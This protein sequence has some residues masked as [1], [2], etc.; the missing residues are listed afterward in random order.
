[1]TRL[2][3]GIGTL[4]RRHPLNL[5]RYAACL[6]F[7]A[8]TSQV[9]RA[10]E[11]QWWTD[12]KKACGLSPSL[13]YETWRQQ[14]FPCNQQATDS[15]SSSST[16]NMA[17]GH[18]LQ[19]NIVS[20]GAN[21]MVANIQDSTTRSFM[22]GFT[23]SFLQRMFDNEQEAARQRQ[24][25]EQ[26]LAEQRRRMEEQRRIAEQQRLD[27][28]F[29]RLNSQLKLQGLPF[30]LA[31][32]PM[33]SGE[34]LQLK[35]MNSSGPD[36]LKLKLGQS[37]STPTSYGLKGLPGIYVG[38]PA[39]TDTAGAQS[40]TT[41]GNPNLA[42]GPGTGTT[43][44]GI[45]GLP[46]IY[47]DRVQPQEAPELAQAATHLSGPD[48]TLAQDVALQ[49]AK[50]NPVLSGPSD[51]PTIQDFQQKAQQYDGAQASAKVAQDQWNEAQSRVDSDK[52]ALDMARAKVESDKATPDQQQAFKQMV[53]LAK[54]DEDAAQRAREIFDGASAHVSLTRADAASALASLVPATGTSTNTSSAHA[55]LQTV[56]A[57]SSVVDLSQAHTSTP[58]TLKLGTSNGVPIPTGPPRATAVATTTP[59]IQAV[60][61][62][63]NGCLVT[64]A[65]H[66]ISTA[67]LPSMEQLRAQLEDAEERI[68]RMVEDREKQ[69]ELGAEAAQQIKDAQ[70][71][72]KKQAIELTAD[73]VLHKAIAGVRSG[74]WESG[75]E[76]SNL[77]K[78]A[79]A[80]TDPSKLAALQS[81]IQQ[82]TLRQQNLKLAKDVL[83]NGKDRLEEYERLRDFHEWASKPADLQKAT[84]QMEG[85]KQ[86]VTAALSESSVKAALQY[87]PYVDDAV[88][89]GSSMIDTSYDLLAEY[90]G[91]KQ[92]DQ[93]NNNSAEYL[94]ALAALDRRV[95]VS[96]AQ[97]SCYGSQPDHQAH[98][99]R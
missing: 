59:A 60:A 72:A 12:Q 43:G 63:L 16:S 65:G 38:G 93:Y 48:Q 5:L 1:M 41:T 96:V 62:D 81:Q 84:G 19:Q 73:Y 29:A 98:A 99:S 90:L 91:S 92:L 82:A 8:L 10:A 74:T 6:V 57:T 46:G 26:Q 21:M 55:S 64:A 34:P 79:Q 30:D 3:N 45:P 54:T 88:K 17:Q 20:Y 18:N 95:R 27:A 85:I 53:E 70:N 80:E 51:D 4:S 32:K 24:I 71:D 67:T 28:M 50:K 69:D 75:R 37:D 33:N 83:E 2:S 11:P 61:Q 25:L 44:P 31:L 47:L 78:L 68:R 15:S 39:G 97:L 52:A 56:P 7:L 35:G 23:N 87:T 40:S 42:S 86:V 89:W 77:N 36:E 94:K 9:L 58:I 49:T 13:A 76:L 14:G 22:N 66:P